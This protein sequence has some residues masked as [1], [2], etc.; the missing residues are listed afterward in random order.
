[1]IAAMRRLFIIFGPSTFITQGI[2]G[3]RWDC[4]EFDVPCSQIG[5]DADECNGNPNAVFSGFTLVPQVNGQA[6]ST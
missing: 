3:G 4:Q 5:W 2:S 6:C 1:M